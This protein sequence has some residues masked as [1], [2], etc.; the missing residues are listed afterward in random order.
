MS[1]HWSHLERSYWPNVYQLYESAD[2]NIALN[3]H[4]FHIC[5]K[6]EGKAF[7]R[8]SADKSNDAFEKSLFY[9]REQVQV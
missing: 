1:G 2:N 5:V 6:R 9:W 8:M 3:T 4:G 7:K